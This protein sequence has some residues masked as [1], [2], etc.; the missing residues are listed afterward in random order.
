ME[1]RVLAVD[2]GSRRVGL[3]LSDEARLLASPL[4]TLEAEPAATLSERLAAVAREVGAVELVVGLPRNLDGSSGAAAAS[5]RGLVD[6]LKRS[7]RLPVSLHD[8]RLSSVAAERHLVGQGVRRE[9]RKGLVDQLA[10]TLI[11]EAFL[12]RRRRA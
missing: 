12:E 2:P 7:T 8:E 4:R 11:L 9:K 3:A 10:A 6:E 1:G 5:A